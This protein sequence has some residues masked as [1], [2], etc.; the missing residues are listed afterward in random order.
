MCSA[1]NNSL[2]QAKIIVA[3]LHVIT[4][5]RVVAIAR[6]RHLASIEASKRPR[7]Q[8]NPSAREELSSNLL[9]R[10]EGC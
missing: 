10:L 3:D 1:D 6:D 7:R 8:N 2:G 4:F 9:S 5:V